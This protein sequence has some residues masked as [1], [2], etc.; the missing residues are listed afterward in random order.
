MGL[1]KQ[2]AHYA[3]AQSL[4]LIT[5][6]SVSFCPSC[7]KKNELP[8]WMC[9]TWKSS[10]N[11]IDVRETWRS[12]QDKMI[13][14]TVW[15]WDGKQRKET[16]QLYYE[17]DTLY[18]R[19]RMEGNKILYFKCEDPFGDTLIF[20]NHR[21]DFPKRLV[22]VRSTQQNMNVWIDNEEKDPNR[23]SFPFEKITS[24]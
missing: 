15:S 10:F 3:I 16:L 4:V 14:S 17:Q 20:V 19:I 18:Y 11:G 22:Y 12:E 23:I 8:R 1:S 6:L 7:T 9:G 21:N 2:P 24:H 5:I 13:G